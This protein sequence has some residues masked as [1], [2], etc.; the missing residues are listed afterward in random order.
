MKCF[1]LFERYIY[2]RFFHFNLLK[3]EKSFVAGGL[4]LTIAS[5]LHRQKIDSIKLNTAVGVM[6]VTFSGDKMSVSYTGKKP[7]IDYTAKKPSVSFTG[8]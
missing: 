6:S 2:L 1:Y 8:E 3:I 5:L 4:D 7:S